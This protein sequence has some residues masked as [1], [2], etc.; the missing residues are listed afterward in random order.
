[1]PKSPYARVVVDTNVLIS[2]ALLRASVPAR[3]LSLLLNGS[4]LQFSERTFDELASRL[5]KPRFDRYI[6]IDDRTRLLQDL[7]SVAEWSV[8]PASMLIKRYS[9]DVDDDAFVHLALV[10]K[11]TRLITGDA[12]LLELSSLR[13]LKILTP[14]DALTELE[15]ISD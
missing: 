10:S 12:D 6:D 1:M 8:I 13:E 3:L 9:R 2:A 11:C 7:R 4:R 15:L 14:R 5:W